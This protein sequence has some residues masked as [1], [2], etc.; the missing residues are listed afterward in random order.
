MLPNSCWLAFLSSLLVLLI[1]M[2]CAMPEAGSPDAVRCAGVSGA[3]QPIQDAMP[4]CSAPVPPGE[5]Y[6]SVVTVTRNDRYGGDTPSRLRTQQHVHNLAALRRCHNLSMEH[7]IVDWNP[8]L[9]LPTLSATLEC[10]AYRHVRLVTVPSPLHDYAVNACHFPPHKA[11]GMLEY[12]AKN[13]GLRRARGQFV[14]L[15]NNDVLLS[16]SLLA[17]LASK[18]LCPDV[19][20]TALRYDL[21]A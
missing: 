8:E 13:V 11:P 2:A 4:H 20:Y 9:N 21:P 15:V 18:Q 16:S 10:A 3:P 12:H 14:L 19:L 5:P 1:G 7:I 17:F 6:L